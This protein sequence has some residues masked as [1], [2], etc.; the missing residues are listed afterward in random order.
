MLVTFSM[1]IIPQRCIIVLLLDGPADATLHGQFFAGTFGGGALQHIF[2]LFDEA[3]L[4]YNRNLI[5]H[6]QEL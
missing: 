4:V 6:M 5:F 2:R 1:P 3:H